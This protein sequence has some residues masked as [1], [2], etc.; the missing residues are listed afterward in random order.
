[1]QTGLFDKNGRQI[2]VGDRVKLILDDG[3]ERVFDVCFKTVQR[4]VKS[5]P[6]FDEE[7]A[8]VNITGI[9]FCWMG[10]DLF[11]CVDGNGIPDN[12]KMEIVKKG[13]M[14]GKEAVANLFR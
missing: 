9:V 7:F 8:K 11:P 2:E 6:D 1:M 13:R 3:E 5:H 14:T 10:Y 12:E 4:T